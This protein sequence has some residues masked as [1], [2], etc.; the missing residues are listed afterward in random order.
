MNCGNLRSRKS[1]FGDG[2]PDNIA[3]SVEGDEEKDEEDLFDVAIGDKEYVSPEEQ[4]DDQS[5]EDRDDKANGDD[6]DSEEDDPTEEQVPENG[7]S[8]LV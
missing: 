6:Q 5:N 4:N 7:W 8:D 2:N 1:T 3:G